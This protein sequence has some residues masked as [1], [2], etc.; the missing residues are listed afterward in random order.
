MDIAR[1]EG[2]DRL[3]DGCPSGEYPEG[4]DADS[5]WPEA[6]CWSWIQPLT[7]EY[8]HLQCGL[9]LGHAGGHVSKFGYVRWQQ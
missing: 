3:F 8:H 7:Y 9:V 1:L 4:R 6:R 2:V 5:D